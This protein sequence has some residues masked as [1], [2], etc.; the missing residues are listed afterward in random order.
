VQTVTG[1]VA[2]DALKAA[3][4]GDHVGAFVI[5]TDHVRQADD[6]QQAMFVL[7]CG[8]AA[9]AHDEELWAVDGM[10]EDDADLVRS[11]VAAVRSDDL[12]GGW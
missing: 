9:V 12:T 4:A 11:L 2:T 6:P 3:L 7:A 1:D 5:L 8:Y 10:T